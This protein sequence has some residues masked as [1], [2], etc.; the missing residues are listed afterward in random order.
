MHAVLVK[1]VRNIFSFPT[2]NNDAKFFRTDQRFNVDGVVFCGRTVTLLPPKRGG[3]VKIHCCAL[4][5]HT[6]RYNMYLTLL[7]L[8]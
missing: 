1:M 4:G 5:L 6:L 8:H 2:V 3:R 7:I